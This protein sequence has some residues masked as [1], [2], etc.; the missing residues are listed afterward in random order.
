MPPLLLLRRRR[1]EAAS[2]I[3]R[4]RANASD[5]HGHVLYAYAAVEAWSKAAREA[6]WADGPMVAALLQDRAFDTVLGRIGFDAKG[7]VTGFEPW[8]WYVWQ[9]DGTTCRWSRG[10]PRSRLGRIDRGRALGVDGTG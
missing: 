8:G 7:D 4:F 9:A 1:P 6:G 10:R 2:V 3:D 5:P